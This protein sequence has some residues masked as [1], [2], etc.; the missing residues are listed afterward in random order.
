MLF[1]SKKLSQSYLLNTSRKAI[2]AVAYSQCGR[3]IAT[4]ECGQN[5]AI[6]VWELDPQSGNLENGGAAGT[7]V[8]EFS[9]HKY[10][11]NCVVSYD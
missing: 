1:N 10:A 11:V 6:K 2:T 4:G 5:P 8:A 9:G 7:I 3:Y